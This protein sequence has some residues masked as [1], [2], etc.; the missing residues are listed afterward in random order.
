MCNR[1]ELKSVEN[2]SVQT[3]N[4]LN[5]IFVENLARILFRALAG[6]LQAGSSASL[7]ESGLVCRSSHTV[8]RQTFERFCNSV[9]D[10]ELEARNI[11]SG[12]GWS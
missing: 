10:V 12:C 5:L 3:V 7:H 11:Q 2:S 4:F 6:D 1:F 9:N 8:L